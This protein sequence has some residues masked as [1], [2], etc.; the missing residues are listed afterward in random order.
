MSLQNCKR[1]GK[2]FNSKGHSVCPQCVEKDNA[3][4]ER[5]RE[6]MLTHPNV[7]ALELSRETGVEPSVITRFWRE[8]RFIT[9]EKQEGDFLCAVCGVLVPAGQSCPECARRN[10]SFRLKSNKK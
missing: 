1:C 3:D 6:Y 5:I 4:F 7:S 10:N 2:L 8:G 9:R